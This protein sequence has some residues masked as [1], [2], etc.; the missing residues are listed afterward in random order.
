VTS[1]L[2]VS[3]LTDCPDR[4]RR[5]SASAGD[6]RR[7]IVDVDARADIAATPPSP[8]TS[9]HATQHEL[10]DAPVDLIRSTVDEDDRCTRLS[11]LEIACHPSKHRPPR[12]AS[13]GAVGDQLNAAD[14]A[15]AAAVDDDDDDDDDVE[16]KRRLTSLFS[17]P[18]QQLVVA[19]YVESAPR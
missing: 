6:V 7:T 2:V 18:A 9:A 19:T 5:R 10:F 11:L 3:C 12:R 4:R 1:A 8:P 15:A 17:P 14:V 13:C 16:M